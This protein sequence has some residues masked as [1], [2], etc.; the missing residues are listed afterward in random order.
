MKKRNLLD[1]FCSSHFYCNWGDE[2]GPLSEDDPKIKDPIEHYLLTSF[3]YATGL[4][5][6]QTVLHVRGSMSAHML[7]W[8]N[9]RHITQRS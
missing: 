5:P 3:A 1:V 2:F 6:T 8:I 4:G 7:S 9:Q